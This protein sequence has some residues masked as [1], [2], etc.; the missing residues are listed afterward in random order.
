MHRS[1][2][3]AYLSS[4]LLARPFVRGKLLLSLGIG[5]PRI[6]TICHTPL[7]MIALIDLVYL[8][9]VYSSFT[10]SGIATLAVTSRLTHLPRKRTCLITSCLL[11]HPVFRTDWGSREGF[12][13]LDRA[14]NS[15]VG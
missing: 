4:C 5:I 10:F 12:L 15:T 7:C 6:S 2:P 1:G 14:D 8:L 9:Y 3:R 13:S 11:A